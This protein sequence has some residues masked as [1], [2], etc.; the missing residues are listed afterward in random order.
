MKKYFVKYGD[1]G[2]VYS[3]CWAEQG[4]S[5]QDGWENIPRRKAERLAREERQ[6]REA[7]PAFSG[8]ASTYI[9]PFEPNG[10]TPDESDRFWMAVEDMHWR[11]PGELI[12]E[13]PKRW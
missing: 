2:N 3:L 7:D 8:Y 11:N 13:K 12:V 5:I 4:D 9:A 6:R 10:L 1:F